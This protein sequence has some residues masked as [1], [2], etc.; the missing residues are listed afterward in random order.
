M[1]T[2]RSS[3]WLHKRL[4]VLKLNEAL[5]YKVKEEASDSFFVKIM[6]KLSY[7]GFP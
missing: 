1:I 6:V 5:A 2:F 3:S 7:M 4:L